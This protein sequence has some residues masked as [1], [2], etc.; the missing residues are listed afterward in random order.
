MPLSQTCREPTRLRS[1]QSDSTACG[2]SQ[3]RAVNS[4]MEI[5]IVGRFSVRDGAPVLATKCSLLTRTGHIRPCAKTPSHSARRLPPPL[6]PNVHG[7]R[8]A[9]APTRAAKRNLPAPTN[10]V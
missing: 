6:P 5:P 9:V 2:N 8:A 7:L 4:S 10:H 1:Q 3:G